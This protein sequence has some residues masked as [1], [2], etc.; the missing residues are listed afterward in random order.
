MKK[1][2][3]P[4]VLLTLLC[5]PAVSVCAQ[6]MSGMHH[7]AHASATIALDGGSQEGVAAKANLHDVREAMGK[8][9]RPETHHM[10]VMF[11]DAATGKPLTEGTVAVKVSGPDGGKGEP[12]KMMLMG[13]GF[14]TDV[15]VAAPGKYT[16]E[17]GTKLGDGKRRVFTF[18]YTK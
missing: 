4:L 11:T 2:L 3:F 8:S 17:V 10:M 18:S 15:T 5:A 6:D 1:R 13:D 7:A 14:G 9:G 16:F 12:A